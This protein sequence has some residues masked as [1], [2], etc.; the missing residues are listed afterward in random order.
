[1]VKPSLVYEDSSHVWFDKTKLTVPDDY[2]TLDV[3]P[4]TRASV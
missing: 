1:M 2:V 4:Q 3:Y